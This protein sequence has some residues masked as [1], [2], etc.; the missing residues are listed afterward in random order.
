MSAEMR[1]MCEM[2]RGQRDAPEFGVDSGDYR[3]FV[4]GGSH[5]IEI[6]RPGC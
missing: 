5:V 1:I 3:K 6:T 4:L 2:G